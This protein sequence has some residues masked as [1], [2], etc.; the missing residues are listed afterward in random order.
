MISTLKNA[1]KVEDLRKRIIFVFYMCAI[2]AVG[3][4]IPIPGVNKEALSHIFTGGGLFSFLDM[5]AGGSLR[6]FSIF[7]LGIMPYINASII[8]Q[9]LTVVIPQLEQLSKEGESGR[10]IIAKYT[11]YL[12]VFLSLIQSIGLYTW[13]QN[14]AGTPILKHNTTF[15]FILVVITLCGGTAFLMWLGDEITERGIGNGISLIIFMGI[16]ERMPQ[17]FVQTVRTLR[18]NRN[19]FGIL[20]F[21]AIAIAV[22]AFIIF[23]DEAKRKI[24][25]QYSKRVVGR[26]I[27]GGQSTYIPIKVN[28]AGVIP[29]IFAISLLMFPTTVAQFIR[30]PFFQKFTHSFNSASFLF[31]F[32]YFILVFAFTYFYTAVI[33]NPNDIAENMKKY[34]GF[35]LGIRP[36]KP[37][38]VYLERIMIRI[39]FLGALFLAFIAVLPHGVM[40]LTNVRG[41]EVGG[42]GLLIIIGV[43][44]E[45][46]RQIEAQLMMRHYEGFLKM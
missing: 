46:I 20:L 1:F 23:I 36:G 3:S 4:H 8:F 30:V 14:I 42:T 31:N 32:F 21:I 40:R 45:T 34:G 39:T 18:T 22:I 43:A 38:A 15:Y 37:T 29:I 7:A 41:F 33:F 9:L 17:E 12:A 44:L 24:P 11:R 27:Y 25:V 13:F 6:R 28:T 5:F 16:I 19:Y 35:I 10:K 26:K 2:F